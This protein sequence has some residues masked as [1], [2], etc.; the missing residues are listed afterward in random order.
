[1]EMTYLALVVDDDLNVVSTVKKM[2]EYGGMRCV[3]ANTGEQALELFEAGKFDI[4]LTDLQ[5]P[6]INGLHVISEITKIDPVQPI[7]V[8]T[9]IE[10]K[11]K[12]SI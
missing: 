10:R 9:G 5:M 1:M 6:N 7:M 3:I 4:V 11:A 8:M 12:I 2:L